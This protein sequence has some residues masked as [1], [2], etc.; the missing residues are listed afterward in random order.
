MLI[1][2]EPIKLNDP[3]AVLNTDKAMVGGV[4]RLTGSPRQSEDRCITGATPGNAEQAQGA[5]RN[6]SA[7]RGE[8]VAHQSLGFPRRGT[9]PRFRQRDTKHCHMHRDKATVGLAQ[10]LRI[11]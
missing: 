3:F 8:E 6:L 5:P 9:S 10:K 4:P 1:L 11:A 7:S 2:E